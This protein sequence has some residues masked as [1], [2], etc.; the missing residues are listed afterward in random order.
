MDL[1]PSGWEVNYSGP[2]HNLHS[3]QSRALTQRKTRNS[4][5]PEK[6]MFLES[7]VE[8][9]AGEVYSCWRGHYLY[10]QK[11]DIIVFPDAK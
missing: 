11:L 10:I 2:A 5:K 9:F 1:N 4:I 8:S 6:S 3:C 7:E